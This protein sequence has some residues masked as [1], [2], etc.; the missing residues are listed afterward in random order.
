MTRTEVATKRTLSGAIFQAAVLAAIMFLSLTLYL[1]VLKWR[2]QASERTTQTAWDRAIPFWPS[3]VWVYLIPYL[4]GP[5]LVGLLSRSTF[6]W[7]VRR[8][9]LLV[10]LSLAIFV[11]LPTQTVRPNLAGLGEG[12]TA[13]LYRQ[14]IEIDEPPANAAPSLHVSLTCLLAFA[15][16]RDFPRWWAASLLGV[17]L[18]WLATLL[19]WQHHLI[20]VATGVLMA[21]VLACP[22]PSSTR[23]NRTM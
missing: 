15:L 10:V 13:T 23:R 21:S 5:C 16:I 4:I 9:L 6:W 11:L 18:V 7:Y 20:D 3:W 22:W 17:S 2:G 12:L 19:T 8:G 14:V 1:T